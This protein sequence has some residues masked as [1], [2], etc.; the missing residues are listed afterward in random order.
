M[1]ARRTTMILEYEGEDI[2]QDIGEYLLDFS[3]TDTDKEAEDLQIN[4]Q[5]RER[6]WMADWFPMRGDKLKPTIL[7]ENYNFDG[8]ELKIPCGTFEVD[9][10]TARGL[11]NVVSLKA[12]SSN[13]TGAFKDTR[14]NQAWENVGFKAVV[15]EIAE[16]NEMSA[17][18]HIEKDKTYD[19]LDQNNK[20][21]LEFLRKI[22]EDLGY[23]MKIEEDKVIITSEEYY[24]NKEPDFVIRYREPGDYKREEGELFELLNWKFTQSALN[25][26]KAAELKY[27]D[28]ESGKMY[29]AYV[30]N[31]HEQATGRVLRLNEK[32]KSDAE[33]EEKCKA[34]LTTEN[35]KPHPANFTL[36]PFV[37][38]GAKT[39]VMV[40]GFG[41]FD[42]KYIIQAVAHKVTS[43]G[44][45]V[46]LDCVK[47]IK[48]MYKLEKNMFEGQSGSSAGGVGGAGIEAMI[49]Y[50][51]A[52]LGKG[53]D[54]KRRMSANY[55]DCSSLVSRSMSAAGLAPAGASWST[56]TLATSG[57]LREIP[58]SEARRGDI[59]NAYDVHA[60][61]YLGNGKVIEAQPKKGVV[62]GRQRSGYKYYRVV[63]T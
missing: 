4:L 20:T 25:S 2:S 26:Y 31:D 13:V 52:Q 49:S 24:D 58:A 61:I 23:E 28:P 1:L 37:P 30:E 62:Y 44:Y 40:E 34:A 22:T 14:R 43:G 6:L 38:L 57:Y 27:K 39:L 15:S 3:Y 11:P 35:K 19:K 8:E 54:Q 46:D 12:L 33:A 17:V 41:Y 36:V 56:R 10:I 7:M 29:Q 5:N 50:A 42:G 59:M 48:G 32:V 18:F 47:Y 51:E 16:R 63:G 21:D 53:Y 9:E 60:M 55:F 45:T